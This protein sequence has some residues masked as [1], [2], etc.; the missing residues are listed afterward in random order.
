[1]PLGRCR[2]ILTLCEFLLFATAAAAP[3]GKGH[4][5]LLQRGL[6]IQGMVTRDDVFHLATY[7]NANY[8]SIHWLWDAN[9]AWMGSPPGFPW[10][11]WVRNEN[12]MPP[13]GTEAAHL[14]QL[15]S[16][17]LGDEANLNDALTRSN[18]VQWFLNV[19][20]NWP[21]TILY[22]NN[23]GGQVD[24]ASLADFRARAQPDMLCFDTY[25][26][27]S[28]HDLNLPDHIG[29]ALGG[30][31]TTWYSDLRRYREHARG[32]NLPL[33]VYRQTFHAVQDYDATV[34][35]D[36]SSS[37]LRLNTFAALA[38]NAKVLIDFTYNTGASSLFTNA[39]G[40]DNAPNKLFA[41][42][43][44][45]NLR[46][47]HLGQALIRLKPIDDATPNAHTTSMMFIRGR[48][49]AG[50][51]N[52]LPIGFVAD[53]ALPNSISDWAADRN[54]PWLRGW[55]VTN[56]A[57]LKNGGTN[58]DVILSW[59]RPLDESLDGPAYSNQVYFLVVNG[60]TAPT[61][62]AEECLQEIRL[63]FLNTFSTVELLDP[64]TGQLVSR[65]LPVVNTR[66]Q[67]VL[68]LNGGDAALFKIATG[69]PFVGIT[70]VVPR[71]QAEIAS[72]QAIVTIHGALGSRY[73]LET[74]PQPTGPSWT[75]VTN[76]VLPAGTFPV[77]LPSQPPKGDNF[78]RAVLNTEQQP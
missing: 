49:D 57:G 56:K 10:S 75:V 14:S 33:A 62:T 21:N 36:P 6:Q 41:E 1:M 17:Q 23:F 58:G 11:R 30:P 71:L 47:R 67:L 77:R 27:R 2:L 31:P 48:N 52:P 65:L 46:A 51:V 18:V 59:F 53:D 44:E 64:A 66:R 19:R 39:L 63:N 38:F 15:I 55:V 40:G 43:R 26:W 69:A 16:L 9:P 5:I 37:E 13:L 28:I 29:P 34:Y 45:V 12:E 61:G 74:A 32:A 76:V 24:D 50:A 8:T 60:L 68:N 54:D 20:S 4:W 72:N 35:R 70:P 25:P 22:A 73:Q 3:I 7:T 42:L 78:Y